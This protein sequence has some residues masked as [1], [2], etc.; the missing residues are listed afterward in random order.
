M[1]LQL[2]SVYDKAVGCFLPPFCCRSKG[3]AVR[4]FMAAVQNSNHEFAKSPSDFTLFYLG[5]FHDES[6]LCDS[7]QGPER[8]ISALE[9][10]QQREDVP[11]T[12]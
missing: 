8:I 9:C 11:A 6:G 3:E 10:S 12:Q 4:S 1:N 7:G 2:Y 5:R